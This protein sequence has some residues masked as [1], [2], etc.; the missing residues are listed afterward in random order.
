MLDLLCCGSLKDASG[1][2]LQ[3]V[4]VQSHWDLTHKDIAFSLVIPCYL[5]SYLFFSFQW[6]YDFISMGTKKAI[7][8]G[9]HEL[10]F[11]Y[12]MQKSYV[13]EIGNIHNKLFE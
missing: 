2:A 13:D 1:L 6:F 4:T 9:E 11:Q 3:V 12:L 7:F 5:L 8:M 10:V